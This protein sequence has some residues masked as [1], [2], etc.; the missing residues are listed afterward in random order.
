MQ[1]TNEFRVDAPIDITWRT[2][3][4]IEFIAPCMP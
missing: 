4:D 1:L 2:L 3:T